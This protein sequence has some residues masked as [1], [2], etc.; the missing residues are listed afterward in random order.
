MAG[1][2]DRA[3]GSWTYEEYYRLDDDRRYELHEGTLV[4]AQRRGRR[5]LSGAKTALPCSLRHGEPVEARGRE[6]RDGNAVATVDDLGLGAWSPGGAGSEGIGLLKAA[7]G[8]VERPFD[9]HLAVLQSD[10]EP[11]GGIEARKN[12]KGCGI[13]RRGS[14]VRRSVAVTKLSKDQGTASPRALSCSRA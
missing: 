6:R 3:A 13:G 11:A 12:S 7:P 9:D 10:A 4:M 8:A 14:S 1:T 2:T 5:Q